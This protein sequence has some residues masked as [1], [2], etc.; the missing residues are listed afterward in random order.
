MPSGAYRPD[1][2]HVATVK[3]LAFMLGLAVAFSLWPAVHEMHSTLRTAQGWA[4]MALPGWAWVVFLLAA[5]QA[6]YIAWMLNRPDWAS[7]WVLMWV[8]AAVAALYGMA[9]AVAIA[10][11]ADKPMPLD[12]GQ[13]RHSAAAWCAAVLLVMSLS[14]YLCGRTSARWRRSFE[15]ETAGRN[16]PWR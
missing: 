12:M 11:P 7:V 8:F 9:T 10:T 16:A 1:R 3:W 2:G 5:A 15:L 13:L 6:A 4:R 14:T